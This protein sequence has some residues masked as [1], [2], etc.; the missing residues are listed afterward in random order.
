MCFHFKSGLTPIMFNVY[1]ADFLKT[2][3]QKC[4]HV[5]NVE[6]VARAELFQELENIPYEDLSNA[7]KYLNRITLHSILAKPLQ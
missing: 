2:L 6:S 4:M 3:S 1:T 7:Q 5:D